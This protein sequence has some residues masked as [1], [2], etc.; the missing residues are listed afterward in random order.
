MEFPLQTGLPGILSYRGHKV[1]SCRT[2]QVG[3]DTGPTTAV[4]RRPPFLWSVDQFATIKGNTI[5]VE[6][7]LTKHSLGLD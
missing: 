5:V 2:S 4:A 1:G 7:G 6:Y 3:I